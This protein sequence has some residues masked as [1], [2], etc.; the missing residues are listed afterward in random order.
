MIVAGFGFRKGAEA[1]SL[2]AALQAA[3]DADAVTHIAT[4]PEKSDTV[5]FQ[6]F[7]VE[8]AKPVIVIPSDQ[9][10]SV[11]VL[12]VSEKSLKLW[13]THSLSE[14]VALLGAGQDAQL[15]GLRSV[16]PDSM[17]TCAIA[18]GAET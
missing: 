13:N 17:A 2:H 10:A 18:V 4:V 16:S 7:A 1:A 3:G 12:S 8:F 14:A 15:T 9:L 6:T 11:Q 5:T